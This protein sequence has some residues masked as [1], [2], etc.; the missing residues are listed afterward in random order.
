[1]I[2]T[3]ETRRENILSDAAEKGL[4]Q[5]DMTTK[6]VKITNKAID[7]V[8]TAAKAAENQNERLAAIAQAQIVTARAIAQQTLFLAQMLKI[9]S[10]LA[11]K[12][13]V[14]V[15]PKTIKKKPAPLG[16]GQGVGR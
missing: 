10:A 2:A 7:D 6:K 14:S 4:A 13:G 5:A 9:Q 3:I 16:P 1:M 11:I 12:A 8:E 15:V